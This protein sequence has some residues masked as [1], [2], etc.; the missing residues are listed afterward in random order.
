MECIIETNRDQLA[1][2]VQSEPPTKLQC[3]VTGASTS[4]SKKETK[5]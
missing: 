3:Q 2:G 1:Q 5:T 4:H